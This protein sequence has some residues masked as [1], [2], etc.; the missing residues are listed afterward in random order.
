MLESLPKCNYYFIIHNNSGP[1]SGIGLLLELLLQSLEI[2]LV[3]LCLY[4]CCM[5]AIRY[6]PLIVCFCWSASVGF[7]ALIFLSMDIALLIP[8]MQLCCCSF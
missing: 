4:Y 2:A 1:I 8:Y 6:W 3:Q 7:Y 5:L